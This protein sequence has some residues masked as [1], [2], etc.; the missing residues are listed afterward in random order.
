[1][2]A[3]TTVC[4]LRLQLKAVPSALVSVV[5]TCVQATVAPMSPARAGTRKASGLLLPRQ[6][7]TGGRIVEPHGDL[8]A[9]LALPS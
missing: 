6:Y 7:S 8:I 3:C 2:T 9:C 4:S 1:M 5:E